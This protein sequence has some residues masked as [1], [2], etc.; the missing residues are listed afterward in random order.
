MKK[1]ARMLHVERHWR[2]DP[3]RWRL[4]LTVAGKRYLASWR[5]R[6]WHRHRH[7]PP[8]INITWWPSFTLFTFPKVSWAKRYGCNTPPWAKTV[9]LGANP[10]S[11]MWWSWRGRLWEKTTSTTAAS[12]TVRSDTGWRLPRVPKWRERFS[13]STLPNCIYMFSQ[14]L[15]WLEE[16]DTIGS[17]LPS[18]VN[19][20]SRPV[21]SW[22][23]DDFRIPCVV[24]CTWFY[25]I[26]SRGERDLGQIQK[27][28]LPLFILLSI[29]HIFKYT[30]VE[31]LKNKRVRSNW[32]LEDCSKKHRVLNVGHSCYQLIW[33]TRQ[34]YI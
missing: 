24:R 11:I 13:P 21:L 34:Q 17:S 9:R 20:Q 30:Y 7:R 3:P 6:R 4:I 19:R 5:N 2:A 33:C 25:I 28:F 1:H 22:W 18:I 27:I 12:T 15:L 26:C 10:S 14:G 16:Q 32:I 8:V 29:S 31:K 23:S